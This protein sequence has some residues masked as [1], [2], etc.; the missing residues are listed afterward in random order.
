MLKVQGR[1][2]GYGIAMI[3]GLALALFSVF[4]ACPVFSQDVGAV[5]P[6]GVGTV[7]LGLLLWLLYLLIGRYGIQVT[8]DGFRFQRSFLGIKWSRGVAWPKLK[9]LS[10]VRAKHLVSR[11]MNSLDEEQRTRDV[12][13]KIRIE[14]HDSRWEFGGWLP[15]AHRM[16]F[17]N[18]IEW[19]FRRWQQG[20]GP[21]DHSTTHR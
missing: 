1:N 2:S 7:G 9:R 12:P 15:D 5:I 17:R 20:K 16:Y 10:L 8:D 19:G 6:I 3:L 11:P 18:L 21:V 13:P 14:T 4:N